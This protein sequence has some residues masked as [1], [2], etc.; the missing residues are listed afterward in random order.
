[1]THPTLIYSF[2]LLISHFHITFSIGNSYLELQER[3]L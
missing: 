2:F 3:S 1:M